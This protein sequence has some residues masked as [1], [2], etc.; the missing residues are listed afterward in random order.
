METLMCSSVSI[1]GHALTRGSRYE[2]VEADRLRCQVRLRGDDGRVRWFPSHCFARPDQPLPVM[3]EFTIDD[4]LP[5]E[6]TSAPVEVTVRFVSGE[7]RWCV[8]ATPQ[9]LVRCGDWVDG[10]RVRFH[11][12]NRHV[13][14]AAELSRE[15]I[16]RML[17]HLD[18]QGDLVECTLPVFEGNGG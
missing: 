6:G 13:I 7:R 16:G 5:E 9:A 11:A 1:Y 3:T 17:R 4:P 15:L 10:T 2:V 14:V 8:F 12:R 18:A